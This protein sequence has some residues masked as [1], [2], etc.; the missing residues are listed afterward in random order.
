MSNLAPEMSEFKLLNPFSKARRGTPSLFHYLNVV[1]LRKLFPRE[2]ILCHKNITSK[3]GG[4]GVPK[5]STVLGKELGE[6][7]EGTFKIANVPSSALH[8]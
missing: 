1:I 7:T 5:S 4:R 6:G 3:A 2:M 8:V